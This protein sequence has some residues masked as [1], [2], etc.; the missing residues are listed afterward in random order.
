MSQE[1]EIDRLIVIAKESRNFKIVHNIIF[2]LAA[3]GPKSIPAIN[4]IINDQSSSEV[5]LYGMETIKKIKD[6]EHP[7]PGFG[8]PF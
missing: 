3:Y 8:S 5:R 1:E 4:E 2:N 7:R 6:H